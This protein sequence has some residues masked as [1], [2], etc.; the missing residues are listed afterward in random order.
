MQEGTW[1]GCR[2][3]GRRMT[4]LGLNRNVPRAYGPRTESARSS[5]SFLC[6]FTNLAS[7]SSVLMKLSYVI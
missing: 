5:A 7:F 1:P 6:P 3:G 2:P 4:S